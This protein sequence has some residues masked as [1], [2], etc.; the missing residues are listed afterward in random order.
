MGRLQHPHIAR[1]IDFDAD[2]GHAYM[3]MEYL[4]GGSLD[5]YLDSIGGPL[6][7]PEAVTIARQLADAL[8]YAH[9]AGMVHRDLK[10]ANVMF[11]DES[12]RHAVLTDFGIAR[13][14]DASMT[15]S[16][17]ML[18]TPAYMAPEQARG[19]R[20]EAAADQYSLGV[21]LH[22][23]VTGVQPFTSDSMPSRSR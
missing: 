21:M 23:M 7:I 10:P 13:L 16:G 12:H 18:G 9:A 19:E 1:V 6:P 8:Q 22:E 20:A 5:E 4:G 2:S 3:V 11:T 15:A 17:I 14:A